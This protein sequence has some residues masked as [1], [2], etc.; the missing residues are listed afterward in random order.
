[1]N[2]YIVLRAL[3]AQEVLHER[4][5]SCRRATGK[6]AI[7]AQPFK[8]DHSSWAAHK[9]IHIPSIAKSALANNLKAVRKRK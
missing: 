6:P 3:A 7:H 1:V 4:E 2:S 9:R 8:L 5:I